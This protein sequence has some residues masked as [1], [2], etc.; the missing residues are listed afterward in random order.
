MARYNKRRKLEAAER[1]VMKKV[2]SPMFFLTKEQ[3]DI[4]QRV[5]ALA[6]TQI[7]DIAAEIDL[8]ERFPFENIR[9]LAENGIFGHAYPERYGGSG[10][11][12]LGYIL[13]L[14]EIAKACASTASIVA[15]HGV[16][17]YCLQRYGTEEQLSKYLPRTINGH[18]MGFALTEPDA[19]SDANAM[20]TTAVKD[21]GSYI[22]NGTKMF[23]SSAPANEAHIVITVTGKDERGKKEFTAFI[24]DKDTPGCTVGAEIKKMGIRGSLTAE[25]VL[26]DCVV[27][28]SQMLGKLGEGMHIALS[29]LDL[30]RISMGTQALGIAQGA[31]DETIR[32]VNSHTG[33]DGVLLSKAQHVQFTLADLQTRVDA[34]RLLIWRAA[35]FKDAGLPFGKEAAMAKLYNSDLAMETTSACIALMGH[36]GGNKDYPIERMMRDAKITQIYEGT[37]EIQKVVIS[38]AIGV[39]SRGKAGA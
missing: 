8:N 17:M 28:A 38:R 10:N 24:V 36:D 33:N 30:G 4:Q 11:D 2:V 20:L 26:E 3:Q 5:A 32:Y 39:G 6:Q 9:L 18:L 12:F 19:G 1:N 16:S 7:R 31:L 14:E 27:P 35:Q 22:I 23:I 25:L 34:G 15:T 21:G 13:A 37:N 29:S